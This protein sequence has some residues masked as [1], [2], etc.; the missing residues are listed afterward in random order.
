[1]DDVSELAA[2]HAFLRRFAADRQQGVRKNCVE[3][4]AEFPAHAAAI[5][6]EYEALAGG[7]A[8]E[9]DA[10]RIGAYRIVRELGRGGQAIVYLARDERLQRDVALKVLPRAH[11]SVEQELRLQREALTAARL[12]DTG[13]CPIY[14]IG[15]DGAHA[16]LA[17]RYVAG[18]TLAARI[19]RARAAGGDPSPVMPLPQLLWLFERLAA[20]LH[21]AHEAGVVHR[22]MKPGNVMIGDD[23]QP[24]L[25]DFGL[26][27]D[28]ESEGPLLTRT[29]DVFGTPAYLP[30]ERLLGHARIA[31]RR[32]DLWALGVALYE[33]CTLRRPFEAPTLDALYRAILT[34][35]PIAPRRLVPSLS[36]DLASVIGACL[37][38][39]P[40]RRYRTAADLAAD[41]RAVRTGEPIRVRPPSLAR[42]VQRWHRRHA[43]LATGLW[44]VVAGLG[45]T[46]VVQRSMLA[47]VRSAHDDAQKINDFL[48]E[49]LLLALTPREARGRE[50]TVAEVFDR[51]GRNVAEAITEPSRV[52]GLLHH[53][54][55]RAYHQIGRRQEAAAAF[56]RAVAIRDEVLGS[57]ARETLASRRELAR[58]QFTR[59]DFAGALQTLRD[60]LARQTAAFGDSDDDTVATRDTLTELLLAIGRPVEAEQEARAVLAIRERTL[61]TEHRDLLEARESLAR[62]YVAQGRRA[63]AEPIERE[64]VTARRRTLGPDSIELE[65][66]LTDLSTLLHDRAS[67]EHLQEKWAEAEAAYAEQIA[68][69]QRIYPKS[70]PG[71]AT[72]VNNVASFWSDRAAMTDDPA[73]R[74]EYQ[75]RAEE[76]FLESLALREATDGPDSTRVAI[77]C[78]NLTSLLASMGR[79]EE[80]LAMIDRALA[81][82]E[83]VNGKNHVETVKALNNRGVL[84]LRW[85]GGEAG[86]PV[87]A[88]ALAR[89]QAHPELDSMLRS[90][91]ENSYIK[92][93]CGAGRDAE[94]VVAIEA[95]HPRAIAQWGED[96]EP[97]RELGRLAAAALR[98]LAR[99]ADAAVWESR[100]SPGTKR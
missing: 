10:V 89:A 27:A 15:H 45:A 87:L 37:E 98:R 23:D 67:Y 5:A 21:R 34:D 71:Y 94:A 4:E 49:R 64:V 81:I 97:V 1:M 79:H 44:L 86:L 19:A 83:R 56:E 68:I 40:E 26:A 33:A 20:S 8:G 54:L 96:S 48:I 65:H 61:P 57:D 85:K 90:M 52:G 13:I 42:R 70:N 6:R 43:A 31:D 50:L 99:D 24:V 76:L 9:P 73:Q 58:A 32:W 59:D 100:A 17:M 38:K 77:V 29:G 47:E 88:E 53:V 95:F 92:A 46:I 11:A 3:Y 35:E 69:A 36:S 82:R 28:V 66:A 60:V 62:C 74:S 75:R 7:A 41:L 18:E 2:V 80:A 55:G 22:D 91:I 25:L 30:P 63:E 39:S 78:G 84:L 16:F 93:L 51:A 72:S 12:E 14:E